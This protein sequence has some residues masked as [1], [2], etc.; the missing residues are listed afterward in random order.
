LPFDTLKVDRSFLLAGLED[1]R[2]SV[3]LDAIILLAHDLGLQVVCEGVETDAQM[4]H[5]ASLECDLVQGFL[6]GEPIDA[7]Q[8]LE[9]LGAPTRGA[10]GTESGIAAL[11]NRLS[12]RKP[13]AAPPVAVPAPEPEPEEEQLAPWSPYDFHPAPWA[14]RVAKKRQEQTVSQPRMA[15]PPEPEAGPEPGHEAD[16]PEVD[17]YEVTGQAAAP[18]AD[19]TQ[20]T[21]VEAA[22]VETPVVDTDEVADVAASSPDE[23]AAVDAPAVEPVHEA[24]KSEQ[25]DQLADDTVPADTKPDDASQDKPESKDKPESNSRAKPRKVATANPPAKKAAKKQPTRKRRR[26]RSPKKKPAETAAKA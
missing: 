24:D 15:E 8:V 25:P 21:G 19:S 16:E 20:V 7:Q 2:G 5:L 22:S 11:W 23:I 12:R 9:A 13:Q 1:E 3:V 6:I 17:G 26:R 4:N 18:E 14:P 10:E